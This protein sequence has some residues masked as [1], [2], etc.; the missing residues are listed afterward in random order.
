MQPKPASLAQRRGVE[1]MRLDKRVGE[2]EPGR[3]PRDVVRVDIER[4]GHIE[5]A[6]IDEE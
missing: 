2:P 3:L 1:M 6:V 4:I 5:N